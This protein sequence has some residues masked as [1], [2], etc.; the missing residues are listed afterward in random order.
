MNKLLK[1][2]LAILLLFGFAIGTTSSVYAMTGTLEIAG[3]AFTGDPTDTGCNSVDVQLKT[4]LT[5]TVNDLG[6]YDHYGIV[7]YD[8]NDTPL[9]ALVDTIFVGTSVTNEA[10]HIQIN[11]IELNKITTRTVTVD[12][13]DTPAPPDDPSYAQNT[14]KLFDFLQQGTLLDSVTGDIGA[15]AQCASLPLESSTP[16]PTVAPPVNSN[17]PSQNIAS[18]LAQCVSHKGTY[19]SLVAKLNKGNLKAFIN[20]VNAQAG[21]KI[22]RSCAT[23]LVNA[24]GARK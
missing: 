7:M 6:G 20:Q 4:V 11:S 14:Q 2:C 22:S 8:D 1:V 19:K 10:R 24:V 5:G 23:T 15:I 21:K 16:V 9:F 13:Y 3:F 12:L 18:L 17:I